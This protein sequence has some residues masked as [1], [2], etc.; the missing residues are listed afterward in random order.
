MARRSYRQELVVWSLL[1]VVMAAIEGGVAGTIA[2]RAFGSVASEGAIDLAVGI[3]MGAG[4]STNLSSLLWASLARGRNKVKA[5]VLLQIATALCASI[6]AVMPISSAGLVMFTASIVLARIFWCGVV[7]LRTTV[8]GANWERGT[9]AAITARIMIAASVVSPMVGL[10]I[11]AM[12]DTDPESFRWM[13]PCA[14]LVGLVAA[15]VYGRVRVRRHAALLASEQGD[16]PQAGLKLLSLFRPLG[17]NKPFRRYMACLFVL[18]SGNM[19]VDAP[20]VL[21]LDDAFAVDYLVSIAVVSSIPV[22]T[23]P[24]AMGLW[25][26]L[27]DRVHV[28]RFR[29][30][31]GWSFVLS[32]ALLVTGVATGMLWVVVIAAI[33]RGVGFAGGVLAWNLGHH[34]FAPPGESGTY[35]GTHVT[36]TGI[37]GLVA[38]LAGVWLWQVTGW[39]AFVIPVG[40][41]VAGSLG[42]WALSRTWERD[43]QP[44][45]R[46]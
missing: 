42:F 19:M 38:P 25:S 31:H 33:C 4:A 10:G 28:I 29:A 12:L 30:V 11:G 15:A 24:L 16:T 5:L 46:A 20:L 7:T 22:L 2:T 17:H 34:D 23:M 40:L 13:F 35:M 44:A 6:P 21:V 9:R 26:K 39:W 43:L 8:W 18:G 41:S 3:I 36:L 27:L 14:T 1:P 32:N 45:G 37:R